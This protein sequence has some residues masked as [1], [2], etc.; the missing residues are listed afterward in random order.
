MLVSPSRLQTSSTHAR[1]L[2]RHLRVV[3]D[4]GR[5]AVVLNANA[6]RVT[7]KVRR[8]F[9]QVVPKDN[10][11][12][13]TSLEEAEQIA[14]SIIDRR[15]DLVMAGGGD[16]TIVNTMNS[17]MKAAEAASSG[18]HRPALPDI[19][20]LKLGTGNG[21]GCMT[22]SA[23]PIED[24]VRVLSGARPQARPIQMMEDSADGTIFPFD[25]L[26][27]DAQLL[28]DY[29]DMCKVTRSHA[30]H[31]LMKSVAGY[32]LALGAK[33]IPAELTGRRP[34]VTIRSVGRCSRIDR[35]T[36][37]EVPLPADSVLFE[38]VARAVQI[39]TVPYYGY[40]M[41]M[42]PYALRRSDRFQLRVST[43]SIP[44][45][46]W[47]LPAIWNGTL[48]HERAFDFLVEGVRVDASQKMPYQTSGDGRGYRDS[49]EVSLSPRTFRVLDAT[50][51]ALT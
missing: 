44:Q 13:S 25:S 9:A 17:L 16:G 21:L 5:V 49:V 40:H 4:H 35:A 38:G 45:C 7:E 18:L 51:R 23:D 12:F 48:N 24:T 15:F 14:A 41:K 36:G 29:V 2:A 20:V 42:F 50:P 19:G 28:N 26:G 31:L 30:A 43:L 33:T 6:K 27:Y 11:F 39:G 8:R 47:N 1:D 37:E 22:G 10:L 46:L 34:D 32:F 3:G